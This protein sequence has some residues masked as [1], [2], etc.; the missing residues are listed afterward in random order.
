MWLGLWHE[1]GLPLTSPNWTHHWA[2]DFPNRGWELIS[3][4]TW[5]ENKSM[6]GQVG[7]KREKKE[8]STLAHFLSPNHQRG[9]VLPY[10]KWKRRW[11]RKRLPSWELP[12]EHKFLLYW[13]SQGVGKKGTVVIPLVISLDRL[14]RLWP[15]DSSGKRHIHM[16]TGVAAEYCWWS[17]KIWIPV[18]CYW[19]TVCSS[20]S[21]LLSLD[22]GFF[23]YKREMM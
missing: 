16:T 21:D 23:T 17:P 22:L 8:S 2:T 10:G 20:A 11:E 12:R 6:V 7:L 1:F 9:V 3:C 19:H 5:G 4:G 14:I 13:S 15:R 18:L